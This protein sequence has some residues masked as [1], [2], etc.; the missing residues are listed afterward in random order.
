MIEPIYSM[1]FQCAFLVFIAFSFIGWC[2]EVLYVGIF[3]E[4]KFVNRGFLYGPLCPIYGFGGMA[5]LCL[6]TKI[7]NS[8]GWLFLCSMVLATVVEYF[9]SWLLE[10]MFHT[11]WWDYSDKKFN[12]HGRVCLLNAILFG[13]M[14]ILVVHFLEPLILHL[15]GLLNDFWLSIV[16]DVI[17]V[18]LAI[19]LVS[20]VK[21][22]VDFQT[23]MERLKNFG[24]SIKS[25]YES[26]S[27]FNKTSFASM[28][29][30]AKEYLTKLPASEKLAQLHLSYIDKF[31][32]RNKNAE[33][34]IKKFPTLKNNQYTD[35]IG[36][37]KEKSTQRKNKKS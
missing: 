5:I 16:F 24:D 9:T 23:T 32:V 2:S 31:N 19:D 29:S 36:F 6:P 11:L 28:L 20:T 4:H 18:V 14:G 10:K 21:K 3:S 7:L 26:E 1:T 37:L 8:W 34:L 17:A 27:W 30:S 13:A 25:H 22:L 35:V 15:I 12:L 33:S